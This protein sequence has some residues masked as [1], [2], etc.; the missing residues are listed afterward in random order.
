MR[1]A[2]KENQY[3][4]K[5][6][7]GGWRYQRRVPKSAL[8]QIRRF[9]PEFSA[10][11]RRSLNTHDIYTAR[12]RRD[13][14]AKEDDAHWALLITQ[15]SSS[16]LIADRHRKVV[17]RAKSLGVSL[18]TIDALVAEAD[19]DEIVR[20]IEI[21]VQSPDAI[22]RDAALGLS[23]LPKISLNDAFTLLLETIRKD[24]HARKSPHQIRKWRELK[25]RGINNFKK[26]VGDIP[27]TEI[28]RAHANTF[29]EWWLARINPSDPS[30][31]PLS[32]SAGNKD[33]DTM[34]VLFGEVTDYL[35]LSIQANP[36]KGLRFKNRVANERP[37][38]SS[39]WIQ[40]EILKS[41]ALDALNSEARLALLAL[42]NTGCRP[43]EIV[44]LKPENIVLDFKIPHVKIEPSRDRELK[45]SASIR[46]VPLAGIS[47]SALR[48][49]KLSGCF[50][51]YADKDNLSAVLN[52]F[53]RSNGLMPSSKHTI[54]G[55]RHSVE[56]R[57]RR[58]GISDEMRCYILGHRFGRERY[59]YDDILEPAHEAISKVSFF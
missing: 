23:E 21:A 22:T 36:F 32:G 40:V 46:S 4:E 42:I 49:A 27:L 20:R 18:T 33:L 39:E 55:F 47:L 19:I 25:L 24:D 58:A 7:D 44:N 37:V 30:V 53:L 14:M 57:M 1:N 17:E 59:G 9:D 5:R 43:S 35:D 15:G 38:F 13:E 50:P 2:K 16:A 41:G 26:V 3:L 45:T 28:N 54:Y 10:V 11:V 56:S 12:L 29:Y 51:R 31:K 34:R 8:D 6:N 52:K 48:E